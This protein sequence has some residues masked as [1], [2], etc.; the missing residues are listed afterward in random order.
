MH[1]P[2]IVLAA[3]GTIAAGAAALRYQATGRRR[4]EFLII[5]FGVA[6]VA[7]GLAMF[8]DGMAGSRA[9]LWMLPDASTVSANRFEG[10]MPGHIAVPVM[11]TAM[12]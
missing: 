7:S 4:F 6:T 5:V 3:F 11:R 9:F 2:E 10:S 1:S 12:D 8:R